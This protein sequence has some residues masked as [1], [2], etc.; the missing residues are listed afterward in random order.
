MERMWV[1]TEN[2]NTDFGFAA[3][4]GGKQT[5]EEGKQW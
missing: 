3:S 4:A 5:K 1:S 2:R